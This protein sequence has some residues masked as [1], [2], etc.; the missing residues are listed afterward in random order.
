[1]SASHLHICLL[2]P[3][4]L[5]W[6]G[7]LLPL[8]LS[9]KARSLLGYLVLY[10]E[11]V[12]H[13]DK[14][15][16]DFW[17][18]RPDAAARRALT[19]ALW[20]VRRSLG[21][22]AG[23]LAA[24]RDTLVFRLQP[25]DWLDVAALENACAQPAGWDELGRAVALYRA[26]FLEGVYDDWA[27]LERERLRELYLGGLEQLVT[28]HKQRG[29]YEQALAYAQRL[30]AAD[31]L[32]EPA[33]RELMRLFHLLNR[34]QSALKQ[35]ATLRALLAEEMGVPPSPASMALYR[36][37]AAAS[38]QAD[39]P[40]L[41]VAAPPPPLLHDPA[42]LPFIGRRDER[43]ALL[44]ALQAA[45]RGH[46]GLAL[47]EGDAGVGK[48]RLVSEIGADARW[49]GF[50][51]GLSKADPL[52]TSAPYRCLQDALQPLL[53]PLRVAQLAEL[54]EPQWLG[55]AGQVLAPLRQHLPDL[56]PPDPM[57]SPKS[58]EQQQRVWEGLARCLAGLASVAPLLLILEDLHWA[59]QASLAAL[60][61]LA[62][63]LGGNRLFLLVT[64]RI[65]EARERA[66]AWEA[67]QLADC[68]SPLT[69]LRLLPFDATEVV[70]MVRRSLGTGEAD[71][72]SAVFA[73]RLQ[74]ETGGNALFLV[75]ML[76]ALLEQGVL[77]AQ[78]GDG[79]VYPGP[80]HALPTPA[81]IQE[82]V[83]GRVGRLARPLRRVLEWAAVL[84]ED[85][86]FAALAN[87]SRQ[88]PAALLPALEELVKWGFL[89]ET[90]SHY[91]FEH[92]RI[93]ESVYQLVPPRRRLALHRQAGAVLE[94]LF[95]GRVEPLAYHFMQG[96][97]WDKAVR[98]NR[99]A[100]ERARAVYAGAEAIAYYGQA[101]EAWRRSP[102]PDERL[103]LELYYER[104]RI[105]QETACY[106]QAGV[107]FQAA[108]D[109]AERIGD[110]K[111]QARAL[112]GTSYLRF[113][114]GDFEAAREAA[115]R[116][117]ALAVPAGLEAES[118]AGLFNKANAL[119]NMGHYQLAIEFY[120]QAV[121]AYESLG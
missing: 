38:G 25:G 62:G 35:F 119:R 39:S 78:A 3:L 74:S 117:L 10:H 82:L 95:P 7:R 85:A 90:G 4:E 32:R 37:I 112:N 47:V 43:A 70:T 86:N 121:A 46:G 72:L 75:E 36:E 103:G 96:Q 53:T 116:A 92:D 16:G 61:H 83:A 81:S 42:H 57:P 67:L 98:Y 34:P 118:A 2:G 102:W 8:A 109:L 18:E 15:V 23:R 20:Q 1:M 45:A 51:V 66:V 30:V 104:G 110:A 94:Q 77:L 24:E 54:V 113:Q 101:I 114:C 55:A 11:R 76:K 63:C 50:Q 31:P 22:A 28:F 52:A 120:E 19:Q 108:Y 105:C 6:E 97:V 91:R 73:R 87:A 14:L 13:R 106:D 99:Q 44:H 111:G 69:R 68:A 21:P 64:W 89:V 58:L 5:N 48:T 59:D 84:G 93:Q 115:E 17:P 41:P 65:A 88:A 49:R 71:E 40:H 26:D 80:A 33:H 27:L 79:W 56:A 107:D 29:D 12:F 9:T 100:G 60:P